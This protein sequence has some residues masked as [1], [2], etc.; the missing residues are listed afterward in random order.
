MTSLLTGGEKHRLPNKNTMELRFPHIGKL[1]AGA[2][3]SS[4]KAKAKIEIPSETHQDVKDR[5]DIQ[6]EETRSVDLSRPG[7]L[8]NLRRATHKASLYGLIG[9]IGLN[10]LAPT[11]TNCI[12]SDLAAKDKIELLSEDH[13]LTAEQ[14]ELADG[15]M[16]FL[17][18]GAIHYLAEHGVK[19]HVTDNDAETAHLLIERVNYKQVSQKE[20][21]SASPDVVAARQSLD[22][23]ERLGQLSSRIDSLHDSRSQEM[24]RWLATVPQPAGQNTHPL[25]GMGLF[26]GG[27]GHASSVDHQLSGGL[28]GLM[29]MGS[30]SL[31]QVNNEIFDA[32]Q[33]LLGEMSSRIEESGLSQFVRPALALSPNL[34]VEGAVLMSGAQTDQERAEYRDLIYQWN[35]ENL[36]QAQSESLAKQEQ[37]LANVSDPSAREFLARNLERTRQN[38]DQIPLATH[39]HNLVLPNFRYAHFKGAVGQEVLRVPVDQNIERSVQ[40]AAG[41]FN[42][43]TRLAQV[44][45]DALRPDYPDRVV[46]HE[47]THAL[48]HVMSQESPE[49]HKDWQTRLSQAFEASKLR[50]EAGQGVNSEYGMT[51]PKEYIADGVEGLLSNPEH[52]KETDQP[53]YELA[54][55]LVQQANKEGSPMARIQLRS[56]AIARLQLGFYREETRPSQDLPKRQN[57]TI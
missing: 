24:Q 51:N 40:G 3:K 5:A 16:T 53:L 11:L 13:N 44:D 8:T 57:S 55:E 15:E 21:S 20:L 52:L 45:S 35:G 1:F 7:F 27:Q 17:G 54:V 4:G 29:G 56:A 10:A 38:P 47:L 30:S 50:Q 14:R 23:Q 39:K 32:Q 22:G 28:G 42:S 19:V 34:S 9:I 18:P 31:A 33:I 12:Q 43:T 48:D 25:G 49:F 36:A 2:P 46:V 26:A 41:F 6:G 37:N